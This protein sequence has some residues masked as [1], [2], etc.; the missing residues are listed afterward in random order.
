VLGEVLSAAARVMHEPLNELRP[1]LDGDRSPT[2]AEVASLSVT[3][4]AVFEG[5]ESLLTPPAI[6]LESVQLSDEDGEAPGSGGSSR[7]LIFL[8]VLP[9][10]SV[11]GLFL[12]GD[13]AMRDI[14]TE[15]TKGTLRRQLSGPIAAGQLILAKALF[16]AALSAICL[17]ILAAIGWIVARQN[18]NLAGFFILSFA[19]IL[20][21]TG[22]A[23]VVYGG[24]G[25][26]RQGGTISGVLLLIF[27]FLGGSFIQVESLPAGV[28]RLSPISPFY[29][30][31]TGYQELIRDGA[32]L[33]V[34]PN[35]GVLAGL[36][37]VLLSAGALLLRRR[38]GRGTA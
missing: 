23:S 29:W 6:I 7:S 3:F 20:A 11:W 31:T 12:V 19:L 1:M 34:L 21:I 30:G 14:V 4:Y 5:A 33:D 8:I 36:G 18:V 17:V 28:R 27:A 37:V 25:T 13:I 10:I 9:G 35:A 26:E 16:T 2:A 24:V 32:V 15:S 38:I 22:Y